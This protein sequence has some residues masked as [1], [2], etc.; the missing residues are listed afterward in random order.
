MDGASKL[1]ISTTGALS[2]VNCED[3]FQGA[4]TLRGLIGA[5]LGIS[6]ILL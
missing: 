4:S 5:A 1:A 3:M 6:L 2:E